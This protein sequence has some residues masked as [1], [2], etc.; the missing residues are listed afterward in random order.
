MK[1]F[2]KRRWKITN[3]EEIKLSELKRKYPSLYKR[4][5]DIVPD[6]DY[7]DSNYVVRID[8]KKHLMEV[9]YLSDKFFIENVGSW[10]DEFI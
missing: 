9:G 3:I 8:H 10:H 7:D 5:S 2:I 6:L 4:L 1:D